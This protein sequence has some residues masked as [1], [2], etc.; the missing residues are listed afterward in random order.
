M[1]NDWLRDKVETLA[2][3]AS[4]PRAPTIERGVTIGRYVVIATIGAGSMGTVVAAFPS[5]TA[6]DDKELRAAIEKLL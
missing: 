1:G 2:A 4:E 6:P 5:G 3:G